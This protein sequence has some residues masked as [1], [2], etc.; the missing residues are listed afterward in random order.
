MSTKQAR[1]TRRVVVVDESALARRIGQRIRDARTRRGV[2]QRELAGD[3]FTGQ[4]VSSL[5]RGA[6][7]PSMAALN[8]LAERLGVGVRELLDPPTE[9][10][11]RVDADL[12]LASGDIEEAERLYR[13][14]AQVAPTPGA[15]AEALLGRAEALCRQNRGADA[16]SPAAE[17]LDLFD[18]AGRPA[19]AAWA[20]YWLASAQYQTDNVAEARALLDGLLKRMRAG[21]EVEPGFKLRLLTSLASVVGWGGDHTS[22]LAYLEEGRELIGDLDPRLQAAYYLSLAQNYKQSGDLEAAVRAGNRSLGLYEGLEARL[23][24]SVL[25]NH[26]ALTYMK[27]GNLKNA[28]KFA[29]L[30]ASEARVLDDRR[31][32][33]W[34]TETQ[35]EIALEAGEPQRA[36]ELCEQALTLGEEAASPETR[37]AGLLTAAKAQQALNNTD[38]ARSA[39]QGATEIAKSTGS[40]ARRRQ[41]LAAYADFLTQ[42]GD[43]KAALAVYREAVE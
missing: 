25:H 19:G 6:V 12:R 14:L 13:D 4:Y 3:R 11:S 35:A 40:R 2:S 28:I 32:L 7:K 29:E 39:F 16:I 20:T 36:L 17:A 31:S 23:E 42:T 38:E 34:V 26:M 41:V 10:W 18:R 21:L 22:A 27:L 15:R 37:V 5:E 43:D 8:Y 9:P 33:A 24:I 1:R 30:A